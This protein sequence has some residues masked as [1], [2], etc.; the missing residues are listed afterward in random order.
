MRVI[1][2]D[3]KG[4][5]LVTPF[6][7]DVRPTPDRVKEGLFSALQFD[8]EGRRVLDLFAGSGQLGIEALSRGAERCVFCDLSQRSLDIVKRNVQKTGFM[9]QSV[10]CRSDYASFL[11]GTKE[12]FDIAFIDPPYM[13]GMTVNAITLCSKVMSDYGT[14]IVEHPLEVVLPE[15]LG[16]ANITALTPRWQMVSATWE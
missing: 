13:E 2:G 11:K 7:R 10:I 8:I 3:L 12:T 14:I 9:S 4:K 15:E 5:R 16:P 6:G 1:T